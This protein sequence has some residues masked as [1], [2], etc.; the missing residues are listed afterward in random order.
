VTTDRG[1]ISAGIRLTRVHEM[2]GAVLVLLLLLTTGAVSAQTLD[3]ET[4]LATA[5][6]YVDALIAGDVEGLRGLMDGRMRQ[7]NAHLYEGDM[8]QYSA[9]LQSR[10]GGAGVR[11]GV[12]RVDDARHLVPVTLEIP[13]RGE[14]V[15]TLVLT[16]TAD[17]PRVVDELPGAVTPGA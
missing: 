12:P 2:A 17:G 16:S 7:R 10:Y 15:F 13:D 14:F 6:A 9:F 5:Q 4:T 3:E 1:W 8:G 11:L